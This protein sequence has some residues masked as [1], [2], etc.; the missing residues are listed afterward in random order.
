M[1]LCKGRQ[2]I[3][4][5][6]DVLPSGKLKT[7]AVDL[8]QEIMN[9]GEE[10]LLK[11]VTLKS[12]EEEFNL[13]AKNRV[14]R[15]RVSWI[16]ETA[17]LAWERWSKEGDENPNQAVE[18]RVRE[19]EAD[20][21]DMIKELINMGKSR[22]TCKKDKRRRENNS[23]GEDANGARDDASRAARVRTE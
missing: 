6:A 11:Q 22:S 4:T 10:H 3:K 19:F 17:K 15:P 9:S 14:G 7:K 13:P 8:L 1:I 21:K 23:P 2:G 16:L 12:N 5:E 20:S 18:G